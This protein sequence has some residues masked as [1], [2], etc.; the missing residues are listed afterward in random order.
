MLIVDDEQFER[1]GIK[2]L[3]NKYRIPV[4][5]AEAE[6]G[7]Q[8]LAYVA[9]NPVH[10]LMTDIK[11]QDVDGLKLVEEVRKHNHTM[12]IIISSAYG[13]FEYARKAIDFQVQRYLLKPIDID[14][15]IRL[16]TVL[17]RQCQV[18][19]AEARQKE[20]RRPSGGGHEPIRAV[21][22]ADDHAESNRKVIQEVLD[23]LDNEYA[24]DIS[25]DS[26]AARVYL[27][28]SYLSHLFKKE[29]GESLIRHM[30]KLRLSKASYYLRHTNKRI[31]DIGEEVGL[32]NLSYFCA[33]FKHHYGY[34][35]AKYREHVK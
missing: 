35:P 16:M 10:I 22:E 30:T 19:Q 28:P 24:R 4:H 2:Y 7:A 5:V 25:L 14:E 21:G 20:Q 11:M 26:I 33:L 15:F 29:T 32:P 12:K 9:R 17:I 34:T 6:D 31:V 18:E 1:D 8:A 13:E 27:S 23:I 3:L